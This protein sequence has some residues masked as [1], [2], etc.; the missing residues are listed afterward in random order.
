MDRTLF[1][2]AMIETFRVC[3]RAYEMAFLRPRDKDMP[4]KANTL[5]KRFLLGAIAEINRTKLLS[6]SQAQKYIGQHWTPAR[7]TNPED[8]SQNENIRA[9]RFCYRALM[10]YLAHPYRPE[11]AAIVGINIKVR[12]RLPHSRTYLEDC[13]DLICWNPE[14]KVLEI[15]DYHLSPLRPFDPA[16]PAVS[17]LV[18]QFL[19]ERLKTR[20]PYEQVRVTFC[21]LKE[22]ACIYKSIDLD[23]AVYRL[24]WPGV[25][26][27]I[28]EMK[29][30]TD[31]APHRS[32][33][34]KR[35]SFLSECVSAGQTVCEQ[36]AG[37][38][39]RTA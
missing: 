8:K 12:A 11:G 22:T 3:R 32:E 13:F 6:S 18:K 27:T 15:V 19:C 33:V 7:P 17:L 26:Q 36:E 37:V 20:F 39:F 1:T 29:N 2:P 38:S 25:V 16:W 30:P 14:T 4:V 28:E 5:C 10:N 34:C 31:Y 21:Q 23:S 24:H 9:F 35:C